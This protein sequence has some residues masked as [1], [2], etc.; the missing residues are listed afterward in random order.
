MPLAARFEALLKL[1][2]NRLLLV[3]EF[4]RRFNLNPAQQIACCPAAHRSNA[5]AA[6]AKQFAGLGLGGNLQLHPAIKRW[7]LYIATQHGRREGNRY[8]AI[9]MLAVALKQ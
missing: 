2:K 8:L 3:V 7:H 1:L 4:H 9:Q 5:L 6:N